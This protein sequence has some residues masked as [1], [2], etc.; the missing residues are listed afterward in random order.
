MG[1]PKIVFTKLF[2][3]L[4]RRLRVIKTTL[5]LSGII[6]IDDD[7][8]LVVVEAVEFLLFSD[9]SSSSSSVIEYVA[10]VVS[11]SMGGNIRDE[12]SQQKRRG[13]TEQKQQ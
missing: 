10:S 9:D 4:L 7:D 3:L 6:I 2:M 1:L 5:G 8:E 13:L 11:T 12:I